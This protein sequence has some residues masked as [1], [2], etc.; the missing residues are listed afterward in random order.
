MSET[1]KMFT[2]IL[3]VGIV[4]V[5]WSFVKISAFAKVLK[6]EK[7]QVALVEFFI[8]RSKSGFYQFIF[9][10]FLIIFAFVYL[11]VN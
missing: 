10:I 6:R 7:K 4:L 11:W 1:M 8:R 9:G 2:G 3:V 5:L